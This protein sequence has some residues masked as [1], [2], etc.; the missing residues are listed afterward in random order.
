L[1]ARFTIGALHTVSPLDM[2]PY[3]DFEAPLARFSLLLKVRRRR[4]GWGV[5]VTWYRC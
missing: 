1:E 3:S 4:S 2:K 5:I